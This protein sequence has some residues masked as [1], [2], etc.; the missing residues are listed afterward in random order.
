MS[1][2]TSIA[3]PAADEQAAIRDFGHWYGGAEHASVSGRTLD[4]YDPLTGRVVA[5]IADGSAEDVALAATA[6]KAAAPGW[7]ALPPVER[8]R[9]LHALA[10][11]VREAVP[12]MVEL[13]IAETGK[14]P[15]QALME[16]SGTADFLEYYAG[17]LRATHGQVVDI[18]PDQHVFSLREPFG[19][20]GVITPWNAPV[21]SGIRGISPALAAGNT[22]IV[23]PSEFTSTTTLLLARLATEAGLPDGVLNVV[24]GLGPAVGEAIVREPVVGK[25]SFTGSVVTGRRVAMIAAERLIPVVLELGGKSPN[26]VFADA[27]LDAAADGTIIGFTGNAGQVCAAATRLLVE[28]S[29]HDAFVEKLRARI[30]EPGRFDDL[31]PII[32]PGQFDKVQSYLELGIEEGASLTPGPAPEE[33]ISAGQRVSPALFVGADNDMRIAREEIFGPIATVIP[34]ETEEEAIR[35]ANDN[36]YGLVSAVWTRDID[37]AFRVSA[38]LETGQVYVNQFGTLDVETPFG[39]MKDSGYG[40]EKGLEALTEFTRVKSVMIRLQ[41]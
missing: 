23:K 20:I 3:P 29:V 41:R 24:T 4:S 37:R 22:V 16:A 36:P 2:D 40:R 27:D 6:A 39:G 8:S 13:E 9:H 31:G 26:I 28:A 12:R 5:H 10:R 15:S 32:T 14:P 38:Q 33:H 35:I 17:V 19:T 7:A 18:G 11:A 30:L 1:S 34:F 25:V 21:Y